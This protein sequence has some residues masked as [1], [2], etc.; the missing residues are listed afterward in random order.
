MPWQKSKRHVAKTRT[1]ISRQR[2]G[3]TRHRQG[4]TLSNPLPK[5]RHHIK[6]REGI[7][8]K[9]R[10]PFKQGEGI[11]LRHVLAKRR[12]QMATST[13]HLATR[14]D[15]MP[16]GKPSLGNDQTSCGNEEASVCKDRFCLFQSLSQPKDSKAETSERGGPVGNESH[17]SATSRHHVATKRHQ[18][19]QTDFG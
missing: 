18:F 16:Q 3:M 8:F 2:Q 9:R 4:I 5:R 17:H 14:R 13:C 6:Q 11:I 7:K 12:H 1:G 19:A 10:Y 15:D